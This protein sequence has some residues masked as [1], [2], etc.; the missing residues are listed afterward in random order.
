MV[1]DELKEVEDLVSLTP[2]LKFWS[3]EAQVT[4]DRL[5]EE[6]QRD[7]GSKGGIIVYENS[8]LSIIYF[9]SSHLINL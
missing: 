9:A 6:M 7:Q 5:E 1:G 4:I 3:D 2:K 8:E